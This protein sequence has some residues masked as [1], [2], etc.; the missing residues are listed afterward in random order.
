MWTLEPRSDVARAAGAGLFLAAVALFVVFQEIGLALRREEQRAWWA[1]TGR[2]LLNAIGIAAV[3]GTL[4]VF[5]YPLAAAIFCGGT[6][7]LLLFGT[8]MW[9]ETRGW[10][11]GRVWAL[12]FGWLAAIPLLVAAEPLVSALAGVTHWLFPHAPP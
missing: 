1:G 11:S 8:S 12:C 9:F 10:R 3:A 2:D 4:R 7:T 6:L 5:G